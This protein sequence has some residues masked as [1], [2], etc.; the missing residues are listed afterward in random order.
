MSATIVIKMR[1]CG[2]ID[3]IIA[4]DFDVQV[5]FVDYDDPH[6]NEKDPNGNPCRI[7][8]KTADEEPR[9]VGEFEELLD[10]SKENML[11]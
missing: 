6:M 3:E 7:R 5:I 10:R 1:K 4:N 9:R 2:V 11:R 8:V